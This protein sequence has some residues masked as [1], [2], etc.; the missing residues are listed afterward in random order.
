MF[1]QYVQKCHAM[2]SQLRVLLLV[3]V[4]ARLALSDDTSNTMEQ[5]SCCAFKKFVL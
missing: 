3:F 1:L 2:F 4:F 5:H